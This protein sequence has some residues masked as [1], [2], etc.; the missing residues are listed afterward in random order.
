MKVYVIEQS[1]NWDDCEIT[2]IF[3]DRKQAE[4]YARKSRKDNHGWGNCVSEYELDKYV[5]WRHREED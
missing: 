3:T 1:V 5:D 2:G 4:K